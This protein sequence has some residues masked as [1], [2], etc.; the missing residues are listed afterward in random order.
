MVA[1]LQVVGEAMYFL[2]KEQTIPTHAVLQWRRLMRRT[3]AAGSR[4]IAWLPC[5]MEPWLSS[6]VCRPRILH[7]PH[8]HRGAGGTGDT[9]CPSFPP[10]ITG[11]VFQCGPCLLPP[12]GHYYWLLNGR[13][14]PTTS[15]RRISVGWGIPSPIDAVFSRCNCDGKTFFIKVGK[16]GRL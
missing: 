7:W 10:C 15:P 11:H 9:S 4:R 16:L 12:A 3:C 5:P 13:T 8:C 6:E 1:L 14:P 2:L